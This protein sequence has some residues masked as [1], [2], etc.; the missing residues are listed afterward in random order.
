MLGIIAVFETWDFNC[1]PIY[2]PID[3]NKKMKIESGEEMADQQVYQILT[4][5]LIYLSHTRSDIGLS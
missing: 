4:R 3:P 1:Q 5:K 2:A